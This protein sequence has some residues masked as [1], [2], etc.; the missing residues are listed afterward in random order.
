MARFPGSHGTAGAAHAAALQPAE[1]QRAAGAKRAAEH[2]AGPAPQLKARRAEAGGADGAAG[3]GLRDALPYGWP[4][5]S[6]T[7]L[8]QLRKAELVR[9][10][11]VLQL[12]TDGLK[13][14]IAERLRA[15]QEAEVLAQGRRKDQKDGDAVSIRTAADP[16]EMRAQ[17]REL[18][19]AAAQPAARASKLIRVQVS[20]VGPEVPVFQCSVAENMLISTMKHIILA[21]L[22][23]RCDHLRHL[24]IGRVYQGYRVLGDRYAI[25]D[26][27]IHDGA[28]LRA[29]LEHP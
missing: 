20:I 14:E 16:Q 2:A 11:H 26:Y 13:A 21:Q 19:G 3:G 9:I 5:L 12:S 22:L 29:S 7:H 4:H 10:A 15:A 24:R 28:A 27:G 18:P 25:A 17:G 6:K 1:L 8:H 23:Q